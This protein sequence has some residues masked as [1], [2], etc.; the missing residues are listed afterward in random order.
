M[1]KVAKLEWK[2]VLLNLQ[3]LSWQCNSMHSD[4]NRWFHPH[5]IA[6]LALNETFMPCMG[7]LW[8]ECF[9]FLNFYALI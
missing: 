2:L 4:H 9:K 1:T 3:V 5:W 8:K 6:V 7:H